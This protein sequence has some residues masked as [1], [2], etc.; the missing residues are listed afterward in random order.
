MKVKLVILFKS[1]KSKLCDVSNIPNYFNEVNLLKLRKDWSWDIRI[2][3]DYNCFIFSKP[4]IY[5]NERI[6]KCGFAL[7]ILKWFKC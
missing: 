5:S 7:N 1:Y 6:S 2:A 4:L 3:K